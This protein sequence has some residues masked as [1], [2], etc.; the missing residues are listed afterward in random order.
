MTSHTPGSIKK[1][2]SSGL[3]LR[4]KVEVEAGGGGFQLK[5]E[6]E[7]ADKLSFVQ[8]GLGR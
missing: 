4:L 7:K 8:H 5:E 6:Q 3:Q 2:D 1:R